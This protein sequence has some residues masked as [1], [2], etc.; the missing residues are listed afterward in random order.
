MP[1]LYVLIGFFTGVCSG[2]LG[3][4]GG[5]IT[6]PLLL[7]ARVPMEAAIT[8]NLVFVFFT[9]ASGTARHGFQGR[10]DARLAVSVALP[11]VVT[12]SLGALLTARVPASVLQYILVICILVGLYLLNRRA[13]HSEASPISDSRAR[14]AYHRT[15]LWNGETVSYRVEVY[16]GICIGTV[17]GFLAGLLGITGGF[18]M[19]PA[20]VG[21]MGIPRRI[22]IGTTL[23]TVLISAFVGSLAHWGQGSLN[24][25]VAWATTLGG[26]FGAQLGAAS[27]TKLSERA[28][29]GLMNALLVLAALYLFSK[30]S[31]GL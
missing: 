22:A 13:A 28:L 14:W 30:A 9:S 8:A 31:F 5:F 21:L 15:A 12:T 10:V 4:G 26:I 27:V 29:N 3:V 1:W 19:I 18:L 20:F 2:L 7:L 6:I 24:V 23:M 16:K 25:T 11:S 17:V